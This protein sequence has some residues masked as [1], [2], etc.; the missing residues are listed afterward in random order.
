MTEEVRQD[1]A[2][3]SAVAALEGMGVPV[4]EQNIDRVI[5]AAREGE[6]LMSDEA[7]RIAQEN[8]TIT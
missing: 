6:G 5:D 8:A 4:T 7:A 3:E 1:P 2:R